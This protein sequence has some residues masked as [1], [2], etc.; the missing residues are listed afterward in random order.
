MNTTHLKARSKVTI[1]DKYGPAME[2]QTE[3]E[4]LEYFEALV[5]H[6]MS[7][8]KT[9][10]EAERLERSN[11]GYFAGYYSHDT[12]ERV[13]RLFKCAHPIFGSIAEK[14]APTAEQALIA[15]MQRGI[16]LRDKP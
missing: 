14:G 10:D 16:A 9:R 1:G 8:G 6:S 13:E 11:L 5:K 15:G 3:A 2:I 4:A 7:F 12:R